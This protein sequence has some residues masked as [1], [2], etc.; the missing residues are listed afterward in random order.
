LKDKKKTDA[1]DEFG[2]VVEFVARTA[3]FLE[4]KEG[5]KSTESVNKGSVGIVGD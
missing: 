2:A 5:R 3:L 4:R 1:G